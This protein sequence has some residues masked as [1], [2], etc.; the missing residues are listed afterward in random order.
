MAKQQVFDIL[1]Q[2]YVALTPEE[3]VRQS[4]VHFLMEQRGYPRE[5]LA[6]EVKL[7]IGG[8][9]LRADTV[10]YRR[11]LTPR[12]IIEYKSPTV[13]ITEKIFQQISAY[14]MQLHADYI[15]ATNGSQ[16]ICCKVDYDKKIFRYLQEI[17]EYSEL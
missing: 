16:T 5:L 2:K 7:Q 1:R 14:N 13:T 4:F 17:P 11:D 9:T 15:I 6:N 8:K 12:M 10:L 3:E